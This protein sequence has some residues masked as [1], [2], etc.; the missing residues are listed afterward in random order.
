MIIWNNNNNKNNGS[1]SNINHYYNH[2]DYSKNNV[3]IIKIVVGY[4]DNYHN[5]ND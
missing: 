2:N 5:E 3:E 4:N 1:N